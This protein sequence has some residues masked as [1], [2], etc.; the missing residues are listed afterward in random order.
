VV[1][2]ARLESVYA[3]NRIAG[4]NPAPSAR[5]LFAI[6]RYSSK[7]LHGIG[8]ILVIVLWTR[9][10][11]FVII[12]NST[13]LIEF[14]FN[15]SVEYVR[16]LSDGK[17]VLARSRIQTF[18]ALTHQTSGLVSARPLKTFAGSRSVS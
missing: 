10:Q 9:S 1:E 11:P 13:K 16:P 18:N 7:N 5:T 3:G 12:R 15:N 4:S 17:Y 6:I 2:G 14:F 8:M